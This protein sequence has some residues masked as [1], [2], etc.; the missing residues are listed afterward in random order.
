MWPCL[1]LRANDFSGRAEDCTEVELVRNMLRWLLGS[2][3]NT[4]ED[5]ANLP[6]KNDESSDE[7][8]QQWDTETDTEGDSSSAS[9][10]NE[11][12]SS[13]RRPKVNCIRYAL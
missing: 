4:D 6:K 5:P 2:G 8:A 11:T 9:S 1:L 7:D 13:K 12:I 3:R 10:S